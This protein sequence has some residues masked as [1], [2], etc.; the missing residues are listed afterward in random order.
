MFNVLGAISDQYSSI[1]RE[2]S[3][4][5]HSSSYSNA[6]PMGVRDVCEEAIGGLATNM[7]GND[8]R[9]ESHIL[10]LT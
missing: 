1:L 7:K 9:D 10:E 2:R 4:V 3:R 6:A 8:F 5:S